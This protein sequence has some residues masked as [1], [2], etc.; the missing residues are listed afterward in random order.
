MPAKKSRPE[1]EQRRLADLVEHPLQ[2]T[3][4]D[5]LSDDALKRLA[6]DIK[7]NG[8]REKIQILPANKAGL[9]KNTTLD[10]HQ[11]RRALLLNGESTTTVIVRHDLADADEA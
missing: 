4:N 9:P 1:E 6:G 7:R 11:R 3:Y 8:L 2:P 10:G 5:G